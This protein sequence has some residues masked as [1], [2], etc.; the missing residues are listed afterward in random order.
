M[1]RRSSTKKERVSSSAEAVV[2]NQA[3]PHGVAGGGGPPQ[4]LPGKPHNVLIA[5][6]AGI[7]HYLGF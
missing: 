2:K 1:A 5:V 6:H 3:Q 4:D 7:K